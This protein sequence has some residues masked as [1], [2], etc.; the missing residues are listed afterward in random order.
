MRGFWI[1]GA[2]VA[3]LVASSA[4]AQVPPVNDGARPGNVIGTGQSL[5]LSN[6]ASNINGSD[7]TSAIAPRLPAPPV[8]DNASLLT[9]VQ[10]AAR[11]LADGRTG[12]AQEAMERAETMALDRSVAPSKANIPDRQPIVRR[13]AAA[14]AA[15]AAGNRAG[16]LE[17]LRS[18]LRDPKALD[19]LP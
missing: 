5:P 10:A 11:A 8:G 14:R 9:Y 1:S 6:N 2:V 12:E 7:T 3:L 15:L 16:S 19:I 4:V 18:I 17:I 13:L